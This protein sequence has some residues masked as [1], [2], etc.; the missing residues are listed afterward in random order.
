MFFRVSS[1]SI[2]VDITG[3]SNEGDRVDVLLN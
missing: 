2:F 3:N 1:M